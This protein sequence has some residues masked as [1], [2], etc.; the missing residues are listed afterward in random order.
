VF[1][2]SERV[3]DLVQGFLDK[4]QRTGLKDAE[5]DAWVSR[6]RAD[7]WQAARDFWREMYEGMA[8]AFASDFGEPR[9]TQW[10]KT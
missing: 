8:E 5:L 3:V 6:F 9:P 2:E 1:W 7:K 10:P 4:W